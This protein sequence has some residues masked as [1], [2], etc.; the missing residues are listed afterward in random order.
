MPLTAILVRGLPADSVNDHHTT[1]RE[2]RASRD[3][4]IDCGHVP[5]GLLRRDI[6]RISC[7]GDARP[8]L[9]R[10]VLPRTV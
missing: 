9:F 1:R 8:V 7:V 10:S 4:R 6:S 3:R 5:L 2:P